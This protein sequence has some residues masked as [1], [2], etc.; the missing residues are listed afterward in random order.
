MA[1]HK[2]D[3]I[4]AQ[5]LKIDDVFLFKKFH[6]HAFETGH[7]VKRAISCQ[8]LTLKLRSSQQ[9]HFSVTK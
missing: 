1:I 7:G 8:M 4:I 3:K 6:A 5:A 9:K 2:G